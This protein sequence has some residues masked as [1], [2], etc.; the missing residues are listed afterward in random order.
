[1]RMALAKILSNL[2]IDERRVPQ[3]GRFKIQAGG[4]VY[5]LRVSTLPISEGEKVVMRILNEGS[6]A[7]ALEDLG[8]WGQALDAVTKAIKMPHGMVLVTGPTGSGK[9]TSLFSVLS[10]LNKPTVN[11]ST[12][13][14]PIEYKVPG[15]NQT[16]V[17]PK[18]GMTFAAGLRALLRQDPNIIMVG[19]IRDTE[20]A[21]LAVQAALTGHLVFAT[22]HTNNAA[23]C[24]PRLL[25]MGIEPFLIASTVRAVVGQRLVRRLCIDCREEVTPDA[26]T[27]RKLAEIFGTDNAASMKRIHELEEE[28]LKGGIG[29]S[30]TGKS[31]ATTENLSTTE[32][33]INRL[34][35]PHDSGCDSCNHTGYKGRIGIYEVLSNSAE[36]QK[37]IVANATSD[38]IQQQ[39]MKEGMITMTLD[40]FIKAIRGQT[41]VEEILRVT[42][43]K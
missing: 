3:D 28:A 15:A 40:G 22:L 26:P 36:T 42:T 33:K 38:V 24:L 5:A 39:A 8:Y 21:D 23:T 41:S 43:E 35:K 29:K 31:H 4:G 11:I 32:T 16:Q 10:Q 9:S 34:F 7:A 27:L 25:D 30:S 14:D 17:N 13:E 20:T 6:G 37:L 18:A 19:E 2:K 12:I 1:M